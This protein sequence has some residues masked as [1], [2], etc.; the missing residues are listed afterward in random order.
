ML[1]PILFLSYTHV[2]IIYSCYEN[3]KGLMNFHSYSLKLIIYAT[4]SVFKLIYGMMNITKHV[5]QFLVNYACLNVK[6]VN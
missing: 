4:F 1:Q 6:D 3:I 5:F 2:S